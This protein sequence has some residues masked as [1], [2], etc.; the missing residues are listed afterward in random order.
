MLKRYDIALVGGI[1][2]Y[3]SFLAESLSRH[4]LDVRTLL[5]SS[6]STR[7]PPNDCG[8]FGDFVRPALSHRAITFD[9][10]QSFLTMVSKARL[11]L[12][13]NL[14][15]LS[16]LRHLYF[17]KFLPGF[18]PVINMATG[19]DITEYVR[20]PTF[21]GWLYRHHLKT[22]QLNWCPPYPEAV[23]SI[24]EQAIPRVAFIPYPYYIGPPL[25]PSTENKE[26]I[27]FHPSH[28]DWKV[29]DPGAHRNSS[30]GNDRFL[31]AFIKAIQNGL[32]AKCIILDRGCDAREAREIINV[33]GAQPYF[34]WKPPLSREELFQEYSRST[35]IVD[36]FDVGGLGMISTEAMSSGRLVITYVHEQS[37]RLIYGGDLPPVL[38]AH[39][40]E[41]I[42]NA[43]W[44]ATDRDFAENIGRESRAWMLRNHAWDTCLS[45]FFFHYAQLTGEPSPFVPRPIREVGV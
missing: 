45:Q 16:A 12:N 39:T 9:S 1:C 30:K 32:S 24:S 11:V 36:Q 29:N 28:L 23:R 13:L 43:L 15:I 5:P 6:P 41:E 22:S 7:I 38:N 17:F 4:G 44:Q 14:G 33:A 19:S 8:A 34:I 40:E 18:P 26:T 25:H 21:R 42:Y 20:Q 37:A 3:D 10:P 2:G 31:R 27:F 35:V